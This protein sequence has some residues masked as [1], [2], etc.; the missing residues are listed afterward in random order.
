MHG[1]A[2]A[3]SKL[4]E[5]TPPAQPLSPWRLIRTV[6][7]NPIETWP[8]PVYE[9]PLYRSRLMGRE[10][11]FVMEPELIRQVLVDQAD[12][13]VKAESLRRAL[14]PLLGDAI[15]TAD[16]ARWRWQRQAAAPIFRPDQIRHAGCPTRAEAG[17][18]GPATTFVRRWSG[19]SP[20]DGAAIRGATTWSRVFWRS[21]TRKQAAR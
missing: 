2:A 3:P 9:Q 4:S 13:F 5:I 7:R 6:I 15:L 19:W 11:V 10:I 16:G 14:Q 20:S 18:S 8:K 12:A 17:S 1:R 21:R